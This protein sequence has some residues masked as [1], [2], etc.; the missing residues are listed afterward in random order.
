MTFPRVLCLGEVLLDLLANDRGD[1]P[2]EEYSWTAY[3]GG[4]P[5][6]VASALVKLG[7]SAGFIGCVGQDDP[8][9]ELVALLQEIGVDDTGIQRHAAAP[10]RQVYVTR[11][12]TGDRQFA[13]FGDRD[14]AAFA[15]AYLQADSLPPELFEAAEFLVLGTLGL[16]YA[17]SR[18]AIARALAL[19]EQHNLKIVVD[20]NW[21]PRFWPDVTTARPLIQDLIQQI[22][23]L[24]LFSAIVAEFG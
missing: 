21:R 8:G 9:D 23:F 5:A 22:D 19:A 16:A 10:T 12:E 15:D 14:P 13:G 1:R 2:I 24:K 17:D 11:S 4:A 3:P 7:T 20:I 18:D 6:N